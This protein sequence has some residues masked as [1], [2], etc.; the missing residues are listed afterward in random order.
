VRTKATTTTV[1]SPDE[2]A[3]D[4]RPGERKRTQDR[5]QRRKREEEV[6]A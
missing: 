2:G 3:R 1:G 5:E 4:D 6:T